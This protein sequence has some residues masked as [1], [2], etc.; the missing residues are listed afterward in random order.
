M[1]G[2]DGNTYMVRGGRPQLVPQGGEDAAL[3]AEKAKLEMWR[4]Q[5]NLGRQFIDQNRQTP[6]GGGVG[7]KYDAMGPVQQRGL[8]MPW[9]PDPNTDTARLTRRNNDPDVERLRGIEA[10]MTRAGRIQGEGATSDTDTALMQSMVPNVTSPGSTNLARV[11]AMVLE[12][13]IRRERVAAMEKF[14]ARERTLAGFEQQWAPV[15]QAWRA[16]NMRQLRV[17]PGAFG[18]GTPSAAQPDA[19]GVV[20]LGVIR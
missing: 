10:S 11:N 12:E 1:R 3:A 20:N 7:G 14:Y 6:T 15:E 9:I 17:T 2:P 19:D 4:S 5:A 18:R 8:V 16:N 13:R